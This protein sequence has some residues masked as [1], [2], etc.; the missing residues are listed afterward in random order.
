LGLALVP[1]QPVRV[2]LD[3]LEVVEAGELD[4]PLAPLGRH[5]ATTR[6]LERRDRVQPARVLGDAHRVLERLRRDPLVVE[7]DRSERRAALPEDLDRAVVGGLLDQDLPP[8]RRPPREQHEALERA[9]RDD[10]P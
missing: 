8:A 5:R 7:R 9:V 6:V 2:V 10:D 4:D 3:D 1:D